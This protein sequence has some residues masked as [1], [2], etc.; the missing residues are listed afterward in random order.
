[1]QTSEIDS[2]LKRLFPLSRSLTGGDNLKTL[3]I[4]KEIVP[5]E[6]KSL[7][8]GTDVYDWTIPAEWELVSG[9][10]ESMNG[11]KIVDAK[12]TPLHV[13][14]Y[15]MP[16]DGVFSSEDALAHMHWLED[17]DEDWIPY[18]TSYYGEDWGF[19]I[20]RKQVEQIRMAG[21]V[22][23]R[24]EAN[25]ND[26]GRMWYGDLIVRG[27]REEEVLVSTYICHPYLAN[28]NLSGL[29][30]TALLAKKLEEAETMYSY[31]FVWV[32]ETIGAIAY[33]WLNEKT[34]QDIQAGLVITTVAGPG[35]IGFKSSYEKEHPINHLTRE[36]LNERA[37]GYLEY[38]FDIHG[39]DERQ[40][41]SPGF[42]INCITVSK[43]KYYEYPQ[44][45]T[46]GDDLSFIS[47]C[48]LEESLSVYIDLIKALEKSEIPL[49]K[50]ERM[51]EGVL[52]KG[53]PLSRMGKCERMLSKHGLYPK[54]GGGMNPGCDRVTD[55]DTILWTLFM[56]D[57]SN[58]PEEI[59][60]QAKVSQDEV[61]KCMQLLSEKGLIRVGV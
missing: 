58:S 15:S 19:C 35:K 22:H 37:D 31:R 36:I 12:I 46:S 5:I 17:G 2:Y 13:M 39:S 18:R 4:L 42:R 28:D 33:C 48:F 51:N 34:M 23:V 20:T 52:Q 43:D 24:I 44:Y 53:Y 40:Y 26:S 16:I 7:K 56:A 8:C 14:A 32:P 30:L 60:K 6:I 1:M 57:G 38:E 59:A 10:V 61:V 50:K 27:K 21:R 47:S 25:T 55:I 9:S 41:S 54:I 3:E 49:R 29:L 45:H 11:T